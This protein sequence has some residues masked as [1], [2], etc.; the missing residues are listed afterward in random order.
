[1]TAR[2]DALEER[3]DQHGLTASGEGVRMT[4]STVYHSFFGQ[5]DKKVYACD[6]SAMLRPDSRKVGAAITGTCTGSGAKIVLTSTIVGLETVRVGAVDVPAVHVR[7]D[8]VLTGATAGKRVTE[9]WYSLA[10][11][12]LLRRTAD[13]DADSESTVGQTHYREHVSILL[14]DLTP[15]T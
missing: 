14:K 12:L 2:W 9:S 11:N 6:P 4:S 10:D 15:R 13:V 8:E 7:G 1:M 3:W 5:V